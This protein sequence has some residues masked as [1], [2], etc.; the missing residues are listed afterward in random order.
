MLSFRSARAGQSVT[1]TTITPTPTPT[2]KGSQGS[3][4]NDAL[5][6]RLRNSRLAAQ[7]EFQ[8]EAVQVGPVVGALVGHRAAGDAAEGA[9]SG[10]GHCFCCIARSGG[11]GGGRDGVVAGCSSVFFPG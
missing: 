8:V 6:L 7:L 3:T 10:T 9:R 4:F 2:A 5:K 11:C 1:T